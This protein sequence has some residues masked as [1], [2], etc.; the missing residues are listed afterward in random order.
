MFHIEI[1][2]PPT[3]KLGPRYSHEFPHPILSALFARDK[4]RYFDLLDSFK[5]Y[6]PRLSTIDSRSE[7]VRDPQFVNDFLPGL[8]SVTLYCFMAKLKP[9]MYIEIGSGNSTKFARRAI[10]DY[11]LN[12]RIVSIDPHPRAEI[13]F[14]CDEVVRK[15][16]EEVD[17]NLFSRCGSDD[18]VF[19]DNSHR[20][21]TN[22]DVTVSFLDILPRLKSGVVVHFHDIF[23]PV[24]YPFQ[25]N[26]RFYSEQYLL[27]AILLNGKPDFEVLLPNYYVSL[28]PE[29]GQLMEPLWEQRADFRAVERHGCGFWIRK[30]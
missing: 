8:D 12:T 28:Q 16:I 25:W 23:L 13:D 30:K 2:F 15:P 22:S 9:M 11:N 26:N 10:R 1:D 17:L 3:S 21:F 27:A 5:C 29:L 6:F 14:L 18:I 24:D 19:I 7:D 4:Q 20:C